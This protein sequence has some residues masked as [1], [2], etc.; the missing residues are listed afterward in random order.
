M[1]KTVEIPDVDEASPEGASRLRRWAQETRDR[2]ERAEAALE[3]L[4]LENAVLRAG[5]DPDQP[6][7]KLLMAQYTGPPE[8]GAVRDAWLDLTT[9]VLSTSLAGGGSLSDLAQLVEGDPSDDGPSP[10][11]LASQTARESLARSRER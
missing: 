6:G 5:L 8:P 4:R 9:S 1:T 10:A 3:P 7:V 11:E 2:A